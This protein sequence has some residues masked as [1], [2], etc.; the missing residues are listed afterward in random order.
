MI[1][2]LQ[3]SVSNSIFATQSLE[4][5]SLLEEK[6]EDMSVLEAGYIFSIELK[7]QKIRS[8]LKDFFEFEH[9]NQEVDFLAENGDVLHLLPSIGE[10]LK[11][12]FGKDS[13]LSL[14]LLSEEND[15]ETLFINVEPSD[16]KDW[17][18]INCFK[19]L[20]FDH[21]FGLFPNAAEKINIDIY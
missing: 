15:W 7:R 16:S 13:I 17:N 4:E 12:S 9:L 11:K 10:C 21:M 19:N 2:S 8:D 14:E 18:Y 6:I 3:N 1:D 20:F 5:K